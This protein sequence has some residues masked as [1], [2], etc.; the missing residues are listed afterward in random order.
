[1]CADLPFFSRQQGCVHNIPSFT[2][3]FSN[4]QLSRY[5]LVLSHLCVI[6]SNL[7]KMVYKTK[8]RQWLWRQVSPDE[9][10][11]ALGFWLHFLKSRPRCFLSGVGGG[12]GNSSKHGC[13]NNRRE[14]WDQIK[15]APPLWRKRKADSL[16]SDGVLFWSRGWGESLRLNKDK[17]EPRWQCFLGLFFFKFSC[18]YRL[19][20]LLDCCV[21][22]AVARWES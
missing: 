11:T 8:L 13:Q 6:P 1:M 17:H 18:C 10:G 4:N 16:V 21:S 14:Q 22:P 20:V 3:H 19:G 2:R 7:Y 9:S 15:W 5:F 12:L